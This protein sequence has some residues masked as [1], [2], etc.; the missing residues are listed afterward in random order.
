MDKGTHSTVVLS[1]DR[2]SFR[3]C[4]RMKIQRKK[5]RVITRVL[6]SESTVPDVRKLDI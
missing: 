3:D 6:A 4:P 1:L 5:E 2:V